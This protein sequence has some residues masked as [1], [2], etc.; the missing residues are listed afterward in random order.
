MSDSLIYDAV[1]REEFRRKEYKQNIINQRKIIFN[2]LTEG[3]NEEE[4]QYIENNIV[5]N[6]MLISHGIRGYSYEDCIKKSILELKF[7]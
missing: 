2:K 4:K 1:Q 5:K 3:L 6:D 7:E